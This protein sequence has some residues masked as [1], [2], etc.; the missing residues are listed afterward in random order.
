MSTPSPS[1][2]QCNASVNKQ[3]FYN[4]SLGPL[5]DVLSMA[6]LYVSI[7]I[8]VCFLCCFCSIFAANYRPTNCSPGQIGCVPASGWNVGTILICLIMLCITVCLCYNSYKAYKTK[9]KIDAMVHAGRPCFSTA[10][11]KV[12]TN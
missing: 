5:G 3:E 1:I 12:I 8:L 2:P 10:Q 11:N 6:G 4:N 9:Q 7:G